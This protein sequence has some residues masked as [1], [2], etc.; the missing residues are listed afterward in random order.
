M[1][2]SSNASNQIEGFTADLR[3]KFGASLQRAEVIRA[4]L[5]ALAESG[6]DVGRVDLS[7]PAAREDNLNTLFLSRL[8]R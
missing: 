2:N 8:R 5:D 6:L 7:A 1:L 3:E 4:L